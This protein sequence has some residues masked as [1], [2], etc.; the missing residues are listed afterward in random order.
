MK[1]HLLKNRIFLEIKPHLML[2]FALIL[3]MSLMSILAPNFFTQGNLLDILRVNSIKGIMSIGMTLILLTG[4]IDLSVGSTFALAGAITASFVMGSHSEYITSNL[5]KLPVIWAVLV[6][7]AACGLLGLINGLVITKLKVEP[8]IAT[9]AMM[10]IGRGLTYLYTG[11]YPIN[12]SE[13]PEAFSILGKGY[14]GI[15]PFPAIIFILVVL[16]GWYLLKFTIFGRS[17]YAIGGNRVTAFLSGINNS[18]EICL[19]YCL[20]GILSGISGIIM[21]SRVA[22]ASPTSGESYEMDVIA[23]VVIGG[24][25]QSGGKGTIAGTVIGIFIFGVIDNGLNILGLPTYYKLLIKGF[26]IILALGYNQIFTRKGNLHMTAGVE[27]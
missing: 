6:G 11:G 5:I 12:F 22:C 17:L 19:T 27:S 23:G 18:R 26:V 2:L 10:T 16:A 8:F 3:L 25:S 7:L 14:I 20:M 15:V 21:T 4:G 9:L 1:Q 24:T 13:M